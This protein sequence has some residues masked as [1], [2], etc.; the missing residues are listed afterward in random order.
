MLARKNFKILIVDDL[1]SIL[2]S[3]LDMFSDEFDI[4]TVTG[5][6]QAEEIIEEM[7]EKIAVI[8]SDQKMESDVEGL[9]FLTKIHKDHPNISKILITTFST[10]QLA[11]EAVN[12]GILYQYIPKPIDDEV[13]YQNLIRSYEL[14]V[15][16]REKRFLIKEK[17]RIILR[18]ITTDR[19]R[20]LS[21]ISKIISC[22]VKNAYEAFK[23]FRNIFLDRI[24]TEG[25]ADIE[26]L[27]DVI[28]KAKQKNEYLNQFVRNIK[29]AIIIEDRD[30]NTFNLKKII[31][32]SIAEVENVTIELNN[33]NYQIKA[34]FPMIEKLFKNIIKYLSDAKEISVTY[35]TPVMV[36]KTPGIKI[37]FKT[38]MFKNEN[39]V[40]DL[41]PIFFGVFHHYGD[42]EIKQENLSIM[43]PFDPEQASI[44][45]ID[46]YME[47]DLLQ[48]F[49]VTKYYDAY[50]SNI[51]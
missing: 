23:K 21:V 37:L 33:K 11:V 51:E 13:F 45:I 32:N 42:I 35:Q 20:N 16:K 30:Y 24:L 46:D 22:F 17:N 8:I 2:K 28:G 41:V 19:I 4:L 9:D 47:E 3:F 10:H 1:H 49:E 5:P 7:A 39:Q 26:G 43:L 27:E 40:W 38:D 6:E 18:L 50:L 15:L 14:F 12:S 36:N 25:A 29:D 31:N 34:C 48:Q 44:T